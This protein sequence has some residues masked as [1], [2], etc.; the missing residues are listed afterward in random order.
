MSINERDYKSAKDKFSKSKFDE[1]LKIIENVNEKDYDFYLLRSKI[2]YEIN[3]FYSS[4]QDAKKCIEENKKK[5][6]KELEPHQIASK[7]YLHMFD[8]DNAEKELKI[9][10]EISSS[11]EENKK[12]ENMI[13]NKKKEDEENRKKYSQY[14]AFINYMKVIYNGGIYINKIHVKWESDWMRC[15]LSSDNIKENETLIRVPDDLLIT[16]DGAQNSEIGKYFDE[17]LKKKLNS[18]HH[19]ILTAYLLQEKQKG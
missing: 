13:Q 2:N 4:L 1:A 17:P 15:I 6:K 7:C 19:C 16:L 5:S 14:D 12:I 9:S 3:D 10:N 18:P 8:N 11:S